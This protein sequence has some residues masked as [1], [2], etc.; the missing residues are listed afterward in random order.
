MISWAFG[1]SC[2]M[3]NE[4]I[5]GTITSLLPFATSTGCLISARWLYAESPSPHATSAWS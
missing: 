5:V 4:L 2:A 1:K 3:V